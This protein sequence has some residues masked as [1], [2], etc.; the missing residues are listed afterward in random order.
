MQRMSLLGIAMVLLKPTTSDAI[1]YRH[2]IPASAYNM[3]PSDSPYVTDLRVPDDCAATP[4]DAEWAL[5]V[6]PM[7]CSTPARSPSMHC[8][9]PSL[10][11]TIC[12]K[13]PTGA[14]NI[15]RRNATPRSSAASR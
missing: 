6:H 9:R 15:P 2:D 11:E 1:I 13:R 7:R 8:A 5:T 3:D 10:N 4:I 12:W 14:V